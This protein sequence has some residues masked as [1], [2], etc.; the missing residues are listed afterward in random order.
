[1]RFATSAK[2]LSGGARH[3][4]LEE[5]RDNFG[6]VPCDMTLGED[7]C[8]SSISQP[9]NRTIRAP[10]DPRRQFWESANNTFHHLPSK[11][12][13]NDVL[14]HPS[15]PQLSFANTYEHYNS[16]NNINNNY[17]ESQGWESSMGWNKC[18]NS[19]KFSSQGSR[20]TRDKNVIVRESDV[21]ETEEIRKKIRL[22]WG[23][24]LSKFEKKKCEEKKCEESDRSPNVIRSSDCA[25]GVATTTS[26]SMTCSS[27]LGA[28]D[29][30]CVKAANV[31]NDVRNLG[32]SPGARSQN[33]RQAF[34]ERI[35]INSLT[36]LGSSLVELIESH[37][38]S[39][40]DS[41][42]AMNK[43]LMWKAI[44]L[45]VL[46]ATET[47]IDSLDNEL[48]SL[49]SESESGDRLPCSAAAG[50][51]LVCHS[52]KSCE[53]I[54]PSDKVTCPEPLQI[55]PS[56][57]GNVENMPLSSNLQI[58]V[59]DKCKKDDINSPG[60]ATSKFVE[61]L[62][63]INKAVS[64]CDATR[65][66]TYS[67]DLDGH[68][69][70]T[71]KCLVPYGQVAG[72]SSCG[73]G[74]SSSS[75]EIKN[76]MDA[77]SSASFYSSTDDT[78]YNTIIS[79]NKES[80]KRACEVFSKLLPKECGKISNVGVSSSSFSYNDAF[81]KEKFAEKKWFASFK[82]KVLTIK[83]E[84]LD[85]LWKK[86]LCLQSLRKKPQTS[87]RKLEL[88]LPNIGS[89]CRKKRSSNRYRFPFPA[90][91]QLS[92][93]PTSDMVN[94][95]SQLLSKSKDKVNRRILKMPAF[96]LDEKDKKISKFKSSNGLVEDPLAI[97][98][99]RAMINP[100]TSEER[101]IF[102]EKFAA[103]GK[104]FRKI[105]SFLDDKTTAD[106]IEFYYKNHK[107]NCL[108]KIKKKEGDKSGELTTVK[109]G[110]TASGR[111][112]NRKVNDDSLETLSEA[113]GMARSGRLLLWSGYDNMKK[114]TGDDSMRE[115][116]DERE[117]VAAE[118]L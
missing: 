49:Q 59:H 83:Y 74:N 13:I 2:M 63:M 99:E 17:K 64:S 92:L 43:L 115:I 117:I 52:T 102:S 89:A 12:S 70:T 16:N 44:I 27:M 101:K 110:L 47:E 53:D 45:K 20:K 25:V 104:D 107:P 38:P 84:A 3:Q 5:P 111:K 61:A 88:D 97:E 100:W 71:K 7:K 18:T 21:N 80:A 116:E 65:Y 39:S 23:E 73:D 55:A 40:A 36:N 26:T 41:S 30:L 9:S 14:A 109:T 77:N 68:Q 91:N 37:N 50:S 67:E 57:E 96:I 103:F 6:F 31:G 90:G 82:E 33:H 56:G 62:P 112:R 108:E 81:M 106:C 22:N 94:Y 46:E 28:G 72:V 34:L 58:S 54:G 24:G 51:L 75:M 11:R 48:K 79:S 114:S 93:V 60:T 32:G 29:T 1:M 98:K 66:G 42:L 69:S 4:V 78:S 113:P 76:G 95:T 19:I 15:H 87:Y 118:A 35:D 86:D 8:R 10:R 85:H 105:A